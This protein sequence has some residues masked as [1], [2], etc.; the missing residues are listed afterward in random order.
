MTSDGDDLGSVLSWLAAERSVS[1]PEGAA[2]IE[3]ARLLDQHGARAVI[4]ALAAQDPTMRDGRQYVFGA[5]KTLNPLPRAGKRPTGEYR[6]TEQEAI[7][8]FERF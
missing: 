6:P 2:L 4:D 7:D 1:V 3:L 5:M 8:A